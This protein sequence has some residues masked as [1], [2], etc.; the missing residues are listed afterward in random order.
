M[1]DLGSL[2]IYV[3]ALV[4]LGIAIWVAMRVFPSLPIILF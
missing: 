3:C 4:M 1:R 2:T